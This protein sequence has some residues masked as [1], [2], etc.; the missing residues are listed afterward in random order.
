MLE[1]IGNNIIGKYVRVLD[2]PELI[3]SRIYDSMV[4][5]YE[6]EDVG[7]KDSVCSWD[8]VGSEGTSLI[9]SFRVV[10]KDMHAYKKELGQG[11]FEGHL[12]V[13]MCK[14]EVSAKFEVFSI[15][16]EGESRH[17]GIL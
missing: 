5:K 11:V 13:D 17:R 14:D 1:K 9:V 12:F 7:A 6:T 16:A 8:L 2:V 10:L 15:E 3:D 4:E